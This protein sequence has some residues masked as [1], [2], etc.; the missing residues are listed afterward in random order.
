MLV[1]EIQRVQRVQVAPCQEGTNPFQGVL[2]LNLKFR[3]LLE[4]ADYRTWCSYCT[5]KEYLTSSSDQFL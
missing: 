4:L 3:G 1:N 2:S 5:L